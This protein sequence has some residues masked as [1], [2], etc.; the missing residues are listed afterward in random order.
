MKA[1]FSI[2][3]LLLALAIVALLAKRQLQPPPVVTPAI[4]GVSAPDLSNPRQV[5]E[6]VRK[7]VETL[8]Q[9]PRGIPGED[10]R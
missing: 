1:I 5:Q 8:M 4:D 2:I 3:S 9:Q 6:D 10:G 7:Q